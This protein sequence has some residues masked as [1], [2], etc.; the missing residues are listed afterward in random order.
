MKPLLSAILLSSLSLYACRANAV[1]DFVWT[2]GVTDQSA[3]VVT[4]VKNHR[5]LRNSQT[6]TLR[7][8]TDE[9]MRKKITEKTSKAVPSKEG[10]VKFIL[11]KLEPDTPY[12]YG[13]WI[14]GVL[15]TE[16]NDAQN[17][18]D[19]YTGTFRTFPKS[20]K[21]A[22]FSF[23]H[24][25]STKPGSEGDPL[26]K[27]IQ[28]QQ[29]LFFLHTGDFFYTD[30]GDNT[31]DSE[32]A[33]R[34][35]YDKNLNC[36]DGVDA[37]TQAALYRTTPI[38]YMWDDHD[39]GKNDCVGTVPPGSQSK[40]FCHAVYRQYVPHYPLA[41]KNETP[42]YQSFTVGRVR[43]LLTDL[44]TEAEPAGKRN[45]RMGKK[46]MHWFK[47]ELLKANEKFPLIVW[48]TT[49]PWNGPATKGADRWQSYSEERQEI[50][51]FLRKKKIKGFCAISGDMHATAIDDGENTDFS[52][53]GG[54][55]FPIFH[56]GP[57][58]AHTSVKAGPYN[59][60]ASKES[61]QFG[62]CEIKD[63]GK[64]IHVR[65]SGHGT[66]NEILK[67]TVEGEGYPPVGTPIQYQFE[68]KTP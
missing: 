68:I 23:I 46:Q 51:D 4:A 64:T 16:L 27:T 53:D 6:V 48:V 9:A 35:C 40:P 59:K 34:N 7:I 42:I 30:Q 63:D 18:D 29:P 45:S 21:P 20:G 47:E 39:F 12:Y 65:W 25:C 67:N 55:G 43:F 60:G 52:R 38:T 36:Y 37:A 32:N 58:G 28:D 33:F 56:S 41:G 13:V 26:F 3:T 54:A 57:V 31:Y 1:L 17:G 10:I 44:R 5:E 22:S 15:D 14:D 66:N 49:V 19:A 50:A 2:G 11:N 8:F 24:T 61:Q 62:L